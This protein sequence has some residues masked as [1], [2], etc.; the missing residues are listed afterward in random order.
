MGT[1]LL[2]PG[3]YISIGTKLFMKM[4]NFFSVSPTSSK[5]NLLMTLLAW[6]NPSWF[7]IESLLR[8]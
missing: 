3:M 5:L 4:H 8:A 7:L 1:K 6:L 2:L